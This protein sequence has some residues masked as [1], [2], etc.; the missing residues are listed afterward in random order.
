MS[1]MEQDVPGSLPGSL[2]A[3]GEPGSR[4]PHCHLGNG[5][6]AIGLEVVASIRLL[7][8]TKC[9]IFGKAT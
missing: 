9:A 1:S 4:L 8:Q 6:C 5:S 3:K 2:P 7:V